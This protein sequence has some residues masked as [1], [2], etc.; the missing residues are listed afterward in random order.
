MTK[1]AIIFGV[2]VG[3]TIGLMVPKIFGAGFG[4]AN[5]ITAIIGAVLGLFGVAIY[6]RWAE[7]VR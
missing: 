5:I 4:V 6:V 7:R 1:G 2:A 3:G